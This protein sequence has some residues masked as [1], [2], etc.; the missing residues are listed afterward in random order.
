MIS[1]LLGRILNRPLS[2]LPKFD[3]QLLSE[4]PLM[5]ID[6]ELTGLAVDTAK[7]T[8]IG[9]ICGKG[10]Q[11]ELGSGYYQIIRAS[12]DLAQSPVI[13]KLTAKDLT[14]GAHVREVLDEFVTLAQ[15]HV[16][17]F[18]N[19]SLD[20]QIIKRVATLLDISQIEVMSIDTMALQHYMLT[21]ADVA[22]SHDALTLAKCRERMGLPAAPEHN[23][24]SDAVATLELLYA[25]LYKLDKQQQLCI[26]DLLHTRAIQVCQL[27]TD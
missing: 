12:G 4:L 16:L 19:A 21:K 15:N 8:S 23:A 3:Q 2:I 14:R 11:I 25:T 13:H 26:N 20:M 5:A 17:V 9:W 10:A 24:L 6:L 27:G 7:V 22:L 1:K 18:H